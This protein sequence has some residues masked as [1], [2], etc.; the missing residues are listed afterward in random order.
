MTKPIAPQTTVLETKWTEQETIKLDTSLKQFG[1]NYA[2]LKEESIMVAFE[3]L[4]HYHNCGN[5]VKIQAFYNILVKG[6]TGKNDNFARV[7]TFVK[8]VKEFSNATFT[9]KTQLF[10]TNTNK[11]SIKANYD[12]DPVMGSELLAQARIIPW[13]K[14]AMSN[15]V[16]ELTEEDKLYKK[17][18]S[19]V[20][21]LVKAVK[22]QKTILPA[23][24]IRD[25]T[26][27]H[28]QIE[29][30]VAPY[31]TSE[32]TKTQPDTVTTVKVETVKNPAMAA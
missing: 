1:A 29:K 15:E 8:W 26:A 11:N 5:P 28:A 7:A 12:K 17:S 25:V 19:A 13:F 18:D 14:F 27:L 2:T 21:G 20:K 4:R 22:D 24:V 30:L 3:C 10:A 9:D 31:T 32:L 16:T 23:D 6:D